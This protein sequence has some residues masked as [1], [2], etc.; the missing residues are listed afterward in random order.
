MSFSDKAVG[1]SDMSGSALSLFFQ[2]V[3]VGSIYE[4]QRVCMVKKMIQFKACSEPYL[5]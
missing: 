5:Q 2:T 3:T 4:Q 1:P